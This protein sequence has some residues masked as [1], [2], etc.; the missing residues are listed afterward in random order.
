MSW[1]AQITVAAL[2][3]VLILWV[4][5][6]FPWRLMLKQDL[7]VIARYVLGCLGFLLP[8]S[9][10]Y[11]GWF[12]EQPS[13]PA[14]YLIALWAVVLASGVAVVSSY[15]VDWLLHRLAVIVEQR[16]LIQH[17]QEQIDESWRAGQI[18]EE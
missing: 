12:G 10:L 9:A 3:A 16:E 15:G 4:E 13:N 11:A 18:D 2:I 14:G 5:H 6:W 1:A 7:P 8:V 17:Y